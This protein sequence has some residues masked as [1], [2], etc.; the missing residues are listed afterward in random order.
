MGLDLEE[1]ARLLLFAQRQYI[2]TIKLGNA[3]WASASGFQ[4]ASLYEEFYEAFVHAPVPPELVGVANDG[5]RQ[6]YFEELRKK[7]RVLL[8][9][10][11]RVHEQ[12]LL[13]MERLGV[14]NEWRDK[15]KL[16]YAKLQKLLDRASGST[17]VDSTSPTSRMARPR[18]RRRPP[19][20]SPRRPR[21]APG[22]CRFPRPRPR[23]R[24]PLVGSLPSRNREGAR[25]DDNRFRRPA[26]GP[27]RQIL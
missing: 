4:I 2:D 23:R 18:P 26:T 9:K 12:N 27:V 3:Q 5:K 16:A 11:L 24:P 17:L 22:P 6:I 13:M 25:P 10:C 1:K 19:R 14:Q 15:S 20:R 8:E 21:C 7:I